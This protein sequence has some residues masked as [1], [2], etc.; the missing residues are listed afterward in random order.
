[1]TPPVDTPQIHHKIQNLFFNILLDIVK[2]DYVI[3]Q[4]CCIY[5]V[6]SVCQP[7][8]RKI[9]MMGRCITILLWHI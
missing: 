7:M 6:S 1:M 5:S 2:Y 3:P 8:G 4:L 9:F